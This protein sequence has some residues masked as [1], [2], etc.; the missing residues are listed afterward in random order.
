MRQDIILESTSVPVMSSREEHLIVS[1]SG[2][3]PKRAP[4]GFLE[5]IEDYIEF[6]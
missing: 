6:R 2:S 3:Q 4:A 1:L 5:S